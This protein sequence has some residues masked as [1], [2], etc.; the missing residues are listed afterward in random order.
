MKFIFKFLFL[1][2]TVSCTNLLYYPDR[3]LWGDPRV[4]GFNYHE[5]FVPSF[6]GTKLLFWDVQSKTPDPENLILY[7]HGNAQNLSSHVFNLLWLAEK[8]SDLVVF[9]YRG[10]GL[11]EG[12]PYPQ[13]LV[14]DGL[15]A[16]NI[17]YDKF[18]ANPKYKRF[19]IYTQSLGGY[20][21]ITALKEFQFKS[22]ISLL[23]LDSSFLNPQEVARSKVNLFGFLISSE[24]ASKNLD[25]ITMPTLVIH[26]KLDPVIDVKFGRDLYNKILHHKK[27]LWEIDEI[28]HGSTFFLEKGIYREKFLNYLK[29]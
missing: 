17:G 13:G 9:D 28:G 3:Y 27:D 26:S 20:V 21:A 18:K 1:I 10:Y 8:S 15:K 14:R 29:K 6:D 24:F 7:F 12:M 25:H 16:I 23:V 5:Y 22:D 4:H 19:I 2:S 11:S